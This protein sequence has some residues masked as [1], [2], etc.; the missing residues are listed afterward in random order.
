VFCFSEFKTIKVEPK[1]KAEVSSSIDSSVPD[2]AF[3]ENVHII[4]LM[5]D[6]GEI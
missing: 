5:P 1:D 3:G 4:D 6:Q 2:G